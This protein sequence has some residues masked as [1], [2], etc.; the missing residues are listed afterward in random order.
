MSEEQN[1]YSSITERCA[2][3]SMTLR[4]GRGS[5]CPSLTHLYKPV[6]LSIGVVLLTRVGVCNHTIP[7]T[8]TLNPYLSHSLWPKH[9]SL[10]PPLY[11]CSQG[12][13]QVRHS[14]PLHLS[15]GRP[16]I[17]GQALAPSPVSLCLAFGPHF[18]Y[19]TPGGFNGSTVGA[20][21]IHKDQKRGRIRKRNQTVGT[22][23]D[24]G[25]SSGISEFALRLTLIFS[26]AFELLWSGL[27][28]WELTD[29]RT[30][31]NSHYQHDT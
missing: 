17:K 8:H 18:T 7:P 21:L 2:H 4:L 28:F 16:S 14:P 29:Y 27:A 15:S 24:G 3:C 20:S 9:S 10:Y 31:K 30:K 11:P 23:N 13:M 22:T 6:L 5:L 25:P 1:H 19:K 26:W 12:P